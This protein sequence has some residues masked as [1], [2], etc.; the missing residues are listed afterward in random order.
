MTDDD[1]KAFAEA[2][3]SLAETFR[4]TVTEGLLHGYFTALEDLPLHAVE[5]ACLKSKRYDDKFPPPVTLRQWSRERSV[6]L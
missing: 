5:R 6:A 3:A 1:K 2:L 4:V